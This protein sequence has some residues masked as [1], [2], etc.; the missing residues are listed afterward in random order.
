MKRVVSDQWSVASDQW[1]VIS[2]Q[3]PLTG[4]SPLATSPWQRTNHFDP[5]V[6]RLADRHYS[7]QKIGSRQVGPPGCR[8][9]LCISHPNHPTTAAAAWIW[10]HPSPNAPIRYPHVG[11]RRIDGYDG[12]WNC[13]F[14]RNE[15]PHLSSDLIRQAV[16][17][18]NREW[19]IPEH[20]YDTYVC[21][22][23]LDSATRHWAR[24][25]WCYL[26]AGWREDGWSKDGL[27]RRLY[28]PT[29]RQ[30]SVISDQ[31]PAT[32]HQP[33]PTSH[34]PLPTSHCPLATG[35][36][37]PMEAPT[38]E[39]VV[40]RKTPAENSPPHMCGQNRPFKGLPPPPTDPT[41]RRHRR[42]TPLP[43]ATDRAAAAPRAA[44]ARAGHWP[45]TTDHKGEP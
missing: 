9:V 40:S 4:H 27:K 29:P 33:L 41:A 34:C 15:S 43:A 45:L 35:R 6:C 28:L 36:N 30:L 44:A 38:H 24:P 11:T 31:L 14:F 23:K 22:A 19:G 39:G 5:R 25:G 42:T 1:P 17:I 37:N 21:P 7:S 8:I 2:G 13:Q 32:D 10:W 18:V 12:W 26:K 20:G 3:L 16:E